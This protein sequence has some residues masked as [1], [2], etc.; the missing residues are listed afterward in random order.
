MAEKGSTHKK[1][2]R[3]KETFRKQMERLGCQTSCIWRSHLR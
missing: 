3:R 2:K 1:K